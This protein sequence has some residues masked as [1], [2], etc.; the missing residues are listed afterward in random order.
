VRL[1]CLASLV[2][3]IRHVVSFRATGSLCASLTP[4][5]HASSVALLHSLQSSSSIRL[6]L[7]IFGV[8]IITAH[9]TWPLPDTM[10][11]LASPVRP[12]VFLVVAFAVRRGATGT[13][14]PTDVLL[15]P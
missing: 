11:R 8:V 9:G 13:F 14:P 2:S 6:V 5:E 12:G 1:S 4:I 7:A 3:S 15:G 10:L